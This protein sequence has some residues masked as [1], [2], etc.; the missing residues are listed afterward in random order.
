MVIKPPRG[1]FDASTI[2]LNSHLMVIKPP[3]SR[4]DASTIGLNSH[5]MV[6]KPPRGRFDASTIHLEGDLMPPP[7]G[8]CRGTLAAKLLVAPMKIIS[9]ILLLVHHLQWFAIEPLPY[10]ITYAIKSPNMAYM[11]E[12]K[13]NTNTTSKMKPINPILKYIHKMC[14]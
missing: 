10:F 13:G 5:F 4:F 14:N 11:Q 2:G 12:S 1:R 6:I 3:R 8:W 9:N 7:L